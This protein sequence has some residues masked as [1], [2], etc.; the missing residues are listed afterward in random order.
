MVR[1]DNIIP[2]CMLNSK[3]R[4]TGNTAIR[5]KMNNFDLWIGD[6]FKTS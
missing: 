5:F 2:R 6:T 4:C 1:K 3:I